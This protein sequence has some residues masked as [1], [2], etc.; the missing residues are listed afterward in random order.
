M[1][2]DELLPV[3]LCSFVWALATAYIAMP[4]LWHMPWLA[5]IPPGMVLGVT[6]KIWAMGLRDRSFRHSL[7]QLL[8]IAIAFLPAA[9]MLVAMFRR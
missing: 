3:P 8:A 5:C 6:L 7:G 2:L 9:L 1:D 4:F